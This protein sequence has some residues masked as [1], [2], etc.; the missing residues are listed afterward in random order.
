MTLKIAILDDYQ[1]LALTMADWS[2]IRAH[3]TI[4]VFDR[5]LA[6]PDEAAKILA[7]FDVLCTIRER[8]PVPRELVER[9]PNLKLCWFRRPAPR[10][11][12]ASRRPS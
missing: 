2:A 12:A 11:R 8:M 1:R 5:N 4:E 7:P 6:V 3:G 10:V 9:L